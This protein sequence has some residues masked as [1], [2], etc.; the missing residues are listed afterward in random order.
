MAAP[1]ITLEEVLHV[2]ALARLELTEEEAAK[3][4]SE[5]DAILDYI[6][7]LEALDLEGVPPTFHSIPMDA[8]FRADVPG[9]CSDRSEIL[10]EAPAS[11]AGGFAVPI[12]LEVDT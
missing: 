2:A 12:V 5:L 1:R 10:G 6:A 8:P 9:R 4:Q 7:E 3:M 11:D